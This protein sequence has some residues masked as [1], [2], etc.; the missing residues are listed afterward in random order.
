MVYLRFHWFSYGFPMVFLWF[1]YGL[2]EGKSTTLAN[3]LSRQRRHDPS[4]SASAPVSIF[5]LP[6]AATRPGLVAMVTV[7]SD[8]TSGQYKVVPPF[9][10]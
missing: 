4:G 8:P 1:S 2:P 9:D 7:E 6:L 3:M 5:P 10:S